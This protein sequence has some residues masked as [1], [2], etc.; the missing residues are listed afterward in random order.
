MYAIARP[1]T[2][3]RQERAAAKYRRFNNHSAAMLLSEHCVAA[4]AA[5]QLANGMSRMQLADYCCCATMLDGVQIA[6]PNVFCM[7]ALMQVARARQDAGIAPAAIINMF[8]LKA[9]KGTAQ[10]MFKALSPRLCKQQMLRRHWWTACLARY[11]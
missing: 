11:C 1:T 10:K 4:S 6:Y 2:V 8:S 5:C 3:D 9:Q 7:R